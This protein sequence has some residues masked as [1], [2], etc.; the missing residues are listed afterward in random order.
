MA[1]KKSTTTKSSAAKKTPKPSAG[2]PSASR[3]RRS[4]PP[5]QHDHHGEHEEE[6]ELDETESK[7]VDLSESRRPAQCLGNG[8]QYGRDPGRPQ[9]LQGARGFAH[10]RP[11][12]ERG[13]DA[14]WRLT[15][16]ATV[17]RLPT[18]LQN[19]S[20]AGARQAGRCVVSSR[21]C[22]RA[23][24]STARGRRMS[25]ANTTVTGASTM[26]CPTRGVPTGSALWSP[27]PA[28]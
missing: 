7:A 20:S 22:R 14:L 3:H 4:R 15:S 19:L 5:K 26:R 6:I 2:K 18:L 16:H 10:R 1:K 27:R 11:G 17:R 9:D 12:P 13:H 8:S 23:A 28:A 25:V 21:R 24:R